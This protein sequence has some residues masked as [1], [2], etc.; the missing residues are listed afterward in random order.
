M[1]DVK[2]SNL[3]STES[4]SD[5]DVFIVNQGSPAVTK[6]T[7]YG[8]LVPSIGTNTGTFGSSSSVPQVTVDIKGRVTS[9]QAIPIN[10]SDISTGT[11]PVSRGGTGAST[12]QGALNAIA[13]STA[14]GQY[15]RGNG[16][17]VVMSAIQAG[18]ITAAVMPAFTGDVTTTAGSTVTTLANTA[19]TA[20]TYGSSSQAGTFTV[21]A[22]GRLTAA[23][24]TTI[25]PA[26]IGA[27][28]TTQGGTISSAGVTGTALFIDCPN[29]LFA[30]RTTTLIA[31]PNFLA[32]TDQLTG[33]SITTNGVSLKA[34]AGVTFGS[35]GTQTVPFRPVQGAIA[36][37]SITIAANT[38]QSYV[39]NVAGATL[40]VPAIASLSFVPAQPLAMWALCTAAGQVTVYLR[41][42][43]STGVA[44]STGNF[45]VATILL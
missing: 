30:I 14:S 44:I 2:I 35:S 23:S 5:S 9:A 31:S 7:T 22:K 29:S 21:D 45:V 28:S 42:I 16:T 20:G 41:N 40:G 39:V 17:N 15:L 19:V 3:P 34:G 13:A 4:V 43:N 18:D 26:A 37:T 1:P 11:L 6:K 33:T 36:T 38:T 10:A 24:N 12:Q 27:I 25:T 8:V 32:T